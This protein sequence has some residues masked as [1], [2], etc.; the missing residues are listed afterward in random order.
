MKQPRI[1]L[2]YSDTDRAF[3]ASLGVE[4]RARGLEVWSDRQ[5][6][7]GQRW[8]EAVGHALSEADTCVVVTSKTTAGSGGATSAEWTQIQDAAWR[9]PRLKIV[10]VVLGS[11]ELPPFLRPWR[12]VGPVPA[13]EP[14]RAVEQIIDAIR[15]EDGRKQDVLQEGDEAAQRRFDEIRTSLEQMRREI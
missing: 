3:A 15:S 6:A 4:L 11:A 10:P 14:Q 2:S 5:I 7:P 1:F 8:R 12:A 9:R 13:S